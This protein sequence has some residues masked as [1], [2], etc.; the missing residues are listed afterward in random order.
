MVAG[1]GKKISLFSQEILPHGKEKCR[2]NFLGLL[3]MESD[4][5]SPSGRCALCSWECIS[6]GSVTGQALGRV[7]IRVPAIH[8]EKI[9]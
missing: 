7:S 3:R 1:R 4:L 5:G 2:L 8:W 6:L 9:R